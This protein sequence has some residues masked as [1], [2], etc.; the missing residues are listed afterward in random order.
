MA[1]KSVALCT[2]VEAPGWTFCRSGQ[3]NNV[4][5]R[6]G[7]GMPLSGCPHPGDGRVQARPPSV[8]AVLSVRGFFLRYSGSSSIL[9]QRGR[10]VE[11]QA[12]D[13]AVRA[14]DLLHET[15]GQSLDAVERVFLYVSGKLSTLFNLVIILL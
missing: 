11:R 8:A 4:S 2:G 7:G 15:G 9:Q 3:H 13:A 1:A 10:L 12:H 6:S 14:L 5:P